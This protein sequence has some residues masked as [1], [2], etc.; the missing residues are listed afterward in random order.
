MSIVSASKWML[1]SFYMESR[2]WVKHVMV[3]TM[4]L[5]TLFI[6]FSPAVCIAS[7]FAHKYHGICLDTCAETRMTLKNLFSPINLWSISR[8][9]SQTPELTHYVL[10]DGLALARVE[11]P[12]QA[13]QD[14][15]LARESQGFEQLESRFDEFNKIHCRLS[16]K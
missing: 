14:F 8:M 5:K 11:Q 16:L 13:R 7:E 1:V 3:P 4:H 15:L 2:G 12:S 10:R 9:T 6:K